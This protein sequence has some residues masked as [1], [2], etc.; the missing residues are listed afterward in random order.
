MKFS[1]KY[2]YGKYDKI[3]RERRIWSRLLKKFL[4]ENVIFYAVIWVHREKYIPIVC[5]HMKKQTSG[6]QKD[7]RTIYEGFKIVCHRWVL[8]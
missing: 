4:M 1:I 2:F 7:S 6:Q 8:K 3:R 5:P